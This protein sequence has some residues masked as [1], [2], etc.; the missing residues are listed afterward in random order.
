[1]ELAAVGFPHKIVFSDKGSLL[2]QNRV[3]PD[4]YWH[5]VAHLEFPLF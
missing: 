2:S 4:W 3:F 5:Y 1:M